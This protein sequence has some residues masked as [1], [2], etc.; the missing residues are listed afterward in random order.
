[1]FRA[2]P[3]AAESDEEFAGGSASMG[4]RL[5]DGVR[6]R[7]VTATLP[8]RQLDPVIELL[9]ECVTRTHD[10]VRILSAAMPTAYPR[11]RVEDALADVIHRSLFGLRDENVHAPA[12]ERPPTL[13]F[14]P[15]MQ[16]A[17]R[18]DDATR[19]L[20][21]AGRRTLDA[22][23][24]S[25]RDLF[26]ARGYHRAR[27]ND[28]TSAAGVS[29]GAFYRYLLFH[30]ERT[31]EATTVDVSLLGTGMWAMGATLALCLQLG[32]P[33][34]PPAPDA[35][36]GNPLTATYQ[37]KDGKFRALTCL[38]AAK[39]WPAMCDVIGRPE[40]ATDERFTDAAAIT[41]NAAAG[42][43]LLRE[44]FAERTADEWRA[45]LANFSGQWAMVQNTLEVADDPQT[46]AN[47]Y[48][49]QCET[50][51]G[52]P[53]KLA[54]APVQFDAEPAKPQRAPHFSQRQ[55]GH[56]AP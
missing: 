9:M 21:A 12:P 27:I 36:V 28:I 1:M 42:A 14:S 2:F 34:V 56:D 40:L 52:V 17:L 53:F 29:H 43:E 10:D 13:A 20:T 15:L 49:Q 55:E 3:E 39:Y 41:A 32:M 47:G 37:T 25:A 51:A 48:I 31:G 5:V 33:W 22:L 11:D 44:A 23:M 18:Q 38:Q 6:S 35:T 54:A 16:D 46:L 8:P 4:P 26:V 7:L 30:R 50:D 19:D 24:T 45:S